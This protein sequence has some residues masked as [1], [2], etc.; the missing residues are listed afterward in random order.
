[1]DGCISTPEKEVKAEKMG[2]I[3]I[4]QLLAV[5]LSIF[6]EVRAL[7]KEGADFNKMQKLMEGFRDAL[8]S[9]RNSKDTSQLESMLHIDGPVQ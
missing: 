9:S 4:A 2:F 1:M 8:K 3:Q 7:I 5:A 6:R